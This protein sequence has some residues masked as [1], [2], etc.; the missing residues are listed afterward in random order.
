M[1]VG[2]SVLTVLAAGSVLL[3][4]GKAFA[5]PTLTSGFDASAT[6]TG[7]VLYRNF[8]SGGGKEVRI[9]VPPL[10]VDSSA[11]IASGD[12]T[13]N[14]GKCIQFSYDGNGAL[15]TKIANVATPC[16]FASPLA[17]VTKSGLDLGSLN[18]LQIQ[19]KKNTPTTSLALNN[20]SLGS[21]VLGNFS[22][23]TNTWNVKNINLTSGFTL[24]GTV[25]LTGLVGSGDSNFIELSVGYVVPPDTEGPATSNVDVTPKPVLINGQGKVTATV[26]DSD[27]G[28]NII[29]SAYYRLN[30]GADNGMSAQDGALDEIAEEVE[31]SFAATKIGSNEV[32]VHGT[33]FLDNVGNPICQTFLV[34]YQFD[35]FYSPIDNNAVNVTKAGQAVPAKWRLTDANGVPIADPTSFA[36]LYS[37]PISC[38]DYQGDIQDSVEEYASGGSG[39]QYNDDGYWQFNW[40][41]PKTYTN[42]CRAMY[43]LLDSGATSPVVKFRFKH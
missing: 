7:R 5:A 11:T 1:K 15:E 8:G 36:G 22:A 30:D 27:T 13:W 23:G 24:T 43:V 39:L 14:T 35:G 32:C 37:Y 40:K 26:D 31:A 16:S 3:M 6:L 17:T 19:I 33:D 41:T 25:A 12:V 38:D 2:Q 29:K 20:V 9:G 34:T 21:D 4:S 10:S 42:T 28:G 18:Y